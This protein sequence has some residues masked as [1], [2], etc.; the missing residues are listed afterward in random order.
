MMVKVEGNE[1]QV[2]SSWREC[3]YISIHSQRCFK[4]R[5]NILQY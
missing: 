1:G 3:G 5:T 2:M 4:V